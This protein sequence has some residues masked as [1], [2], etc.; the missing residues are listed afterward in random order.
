MKKDNHEDTLLSI[1]YGQSNIGLA[2]GRNGFS[3]PLHVVSGKNH[4]LA[5]QEIGRI[6]YENKV[7]KIIMGL[8]LSA[9]NKETEQSLLVRQ[10]ANKIRLQLKKPVEFVSEYFTSQT[11]L[12]ESISMGTPQKGRSSIDH[13]AAAIILKNYYEKK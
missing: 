11:A 9:E 3:M 6:A 4:A 2:L 1:D 12:E 8:P 13:I 10:F 5:L 7:D